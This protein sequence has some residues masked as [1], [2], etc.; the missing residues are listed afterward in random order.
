MIG[1]IFLLGEK[2]KTLV[3]GRLEKF[4]EEMQMGYAQILGI[5]LALSD[6]YA[7]IFD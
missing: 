3:T 5:W 7:A 6:W 4:I 1:T 2:G